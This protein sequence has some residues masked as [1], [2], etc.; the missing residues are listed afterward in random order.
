MKSKLR[1]WILSGLLI[2]GAVMAPLD[3]ASSAD[4]AARTRTVLDICP[5]T[6]GASGAL[7]TSF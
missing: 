4:L 2:F 6:F 5:P 1:I 3:V 7:K